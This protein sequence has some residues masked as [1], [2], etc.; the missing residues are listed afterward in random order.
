M[1]EFTG[2]GSTQQKEEGTQSTPSCGLCRLN[3]YHLNTELV[4]SS[5]I[6]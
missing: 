5:G 1:A 3:L 6:F 4:N 2:N